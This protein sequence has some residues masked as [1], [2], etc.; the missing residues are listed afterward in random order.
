MSEKLKAI[1][2]HSFFAIWLLILL[3][4]VWTFSWFDLPQPDDVGPIFFLAATLVSSFKVLRIKKRKD[5]RV[6]L[7]IPL[8]S[9]FGL[10]EEIGYG[11]E[12]DLVDPLVIPGIERQITDIHNILLVALWAIQDF[13]ESISWNGE[14]FQQSINMDIHLLLIALAAFIVHKSAQANSKSFSFGAFVLIQIIALLAV[15]VASIFVPISQ[16]FGGNFQYRSIAVLQVSAFV[17]SLALMYFFLLGQYGAQNQSASIMENKIQQSQ[18]KRA[19]ILVKILAFMTILQ[20]LS[21]V[22]AVFSNLHMAERFLPVLSLITG[23]ILLHLVGINIMGLSEYPVKPITRFLNRVL[24]FLSEY[25]S[26]IFITIAGMEIFIAQLIDTELV[27]V[28]DYL[29]LSEQW[30]DGLNSWIEE[31]FEA[32]AGIQLVLA[33]FFI[34][35]PNPNESLENKQDKK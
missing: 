23:N 1:L 28:R 35:E 17:I 22:G 27:S 4:V 34:P 18:K 26:Y 8:F 5:I 29:S 24:D 7:L 14:L 6:Y 10:L 11:W 30:L 2:G 15:S 33:A 21:A 25:P 32:I 16:Q 3:F 19:I 9:L 20:F 12:L 31:T 13:L